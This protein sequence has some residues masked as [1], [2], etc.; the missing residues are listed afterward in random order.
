MTITIKK[1]TKTKLF[2]IKKKINSFILIFEMFFLD[3]NKKNC[4]TVY[5]PC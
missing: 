2:K 4:Y 1:K 3:R 5:L